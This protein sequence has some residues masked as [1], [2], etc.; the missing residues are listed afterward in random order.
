MTSLLSPAAYY[1]LECP[2]REQCEANATVGDYGRVVRVPL[3][4]DRRIFTPIA[5]F[6]PKWEKAYNR[7][8]SVERVNGGGWRGAGRRPQRIWLSIV[9][10]SKNQ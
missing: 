6:S 5:S 8:S 3:K 10:A 4:L 2:G 1:G 9:S 7:R